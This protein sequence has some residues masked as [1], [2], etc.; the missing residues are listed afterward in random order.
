MFLFLSQYRATHSDR[1]LLGIAYHIPMQGSTETETGE[2]QDEDDKKHS[3][4]RKQSQK[5]IRIFFDIE[6]GEHHFVI[7]CCCF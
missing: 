6:G 1:I 7:L 2:A 5:R 4:C 3:S